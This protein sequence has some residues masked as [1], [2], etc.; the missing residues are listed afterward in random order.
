MES[1][2]GSAAKSCYARPGIIESLASHAPPPGRLRVLS[3]FDPLVRD[4]KRLHRLFNFDYRIEI[5]V[6]EAE[7]K[8][9][10]YVFP[11]LEADRMIGRIDMKAQRKDDALHVTGL[12]LEPKI[13]FSQARQKNLNAELNRHARFIG[14][15]NVTY[16]RGYLKTP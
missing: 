16:D 5:F 10:Y 9:G 7:R 4:R 14:V 1:A 12:W 2:N 3:P 11:L 6:P 8:Y 15:K 13:K